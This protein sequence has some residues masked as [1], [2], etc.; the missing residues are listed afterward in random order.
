MSAI[1]NENKSAK[2]F[3]FV[4]LQSVGTTMLSCVQLKN[5]H[6]FVIPSLPKFN[7]RFPMK[8]R[9]KLATVKRRLR[10]MARRDQSWKKLVLLVKLHLL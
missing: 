4:R 8:R 3:A 5:N 7:L 9:M 10:M 6:I 1:N 2:A